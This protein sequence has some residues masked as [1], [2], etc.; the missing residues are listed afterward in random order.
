MSS[1]TRFKS[2]K[3]SGTMFSYDRTW[4]EI[5]VMLEE[6]KARQ[7]QWR[8]HYDRCKDNRDRTGMKDAARNHKALEGV[9]KTLKWVCGDEDVKHPLH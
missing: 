3:T 7:Y 2:A 9:I 8:K 5:E 1:N 6:A 4:E